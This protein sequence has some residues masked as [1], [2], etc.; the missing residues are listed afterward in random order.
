MTTNTTTGTDTAEAE[1]VTAVLDTGAGRTAARLGR[2]E[3]LAG[4]RG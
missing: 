1:A 2:A 3:V 4:G